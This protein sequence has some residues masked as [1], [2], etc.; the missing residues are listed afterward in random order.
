MVPQSEGLGQEQD[1]PQ[2]MQQPP[3]Q[4]TLSRA[5]RRPFEPLDSIPL[6]RKALVSF[7]LDRVTQDHLVDHGWLKGTVTLYTNYIRKWQLCV[8]SKNDSLSPTIV[9][10][11]RF[12]ISLEDRGQ[13]SGPLTQIGVP[14]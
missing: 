13:V 3:A 7:G 8:I 6:L 11:L 12:R 10:V 4:R 5:G 9:Q 1:L 2:T 14:L